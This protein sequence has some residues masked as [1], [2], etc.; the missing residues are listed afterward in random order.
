MTPQQMQYFILQQ[1]QHSQQAMPYN[2]Q[3]LVD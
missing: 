1:Q 2:T 3:A